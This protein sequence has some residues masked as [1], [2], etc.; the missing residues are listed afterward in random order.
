MD[1]VE[2][3][4]NF[5]LQSNGFDWRM[6]GEWPLVIL[7][8]LFAAVSAAMGFAVAVIWPMK[9]IATPSQTVRR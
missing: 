6:D 4:P 7:S 8:L 1:N 5:S 9:I 2:E 3:C